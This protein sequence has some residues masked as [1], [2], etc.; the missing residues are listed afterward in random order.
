MELVKQLS[1]LK[2]IEASTIIPHEQLEKLHSN[3]NFKISLVEDFMNNLVMKLTTTV[4]GGTNETNRTYKK[5]PNT[6]WD[7]LKQDFLESNSIL[8][9]WLASLFSP[10]NFKDILVTTNTV[11]KVC[12]H[13]DYYLSEKP[14]VHFS[15][16]DSPVDSQ[17]E[18]DPPFIRLKKEVETCL[19]ISQNPEII[20]YLKALDTALNNLTITLQSKNED[21]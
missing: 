21:S 6:W 15:W 1:N 13:S 10:P 5:E 17:G 20:C 19:R 8:K 11:T 4:L 18:F 2:Q 12:P 9:K 14:L 16:L 3:L 7:H